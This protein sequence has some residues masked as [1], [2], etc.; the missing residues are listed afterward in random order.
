[1]EARD[2]ENGLKQEK[3]R[4]R[5]R[6]TGRIDERT[7]EERHRKPKTQRVDQRKR[8]NYSGNQR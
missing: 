7:E 6:K 3:E 5:K 8:M 4:K 1:M 2:R